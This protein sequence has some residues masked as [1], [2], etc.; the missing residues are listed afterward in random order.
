MTL[1]KFATPLTI[2]AAVTAIIVYIKTTSP[3]Q[4][5]TAT[6]GSVPQPATIPTFAA[7]PLPS[8]GN[9]N[10]ATPTPPR[11]AQGTSYLPLIPGS[12]LTVNNGFGAPTQSISSYNLVQGCDDCE[13]GNNDG[14]PQTGFN[15]YPVVA[16]SAGL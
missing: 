9:P 1:E 2:V 15:Y 12:G 3:K 8:P 14:T 10:P 11:V 5:Q 7:I 4:T 13:G 6:P 16:Q